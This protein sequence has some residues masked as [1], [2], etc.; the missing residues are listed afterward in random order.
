VTPEDLALYWN[1]AGR[2]HH[3]PPSNRTPEGFDPAAYLRRCFFS[4]V[5]SVLEFGCG[6]GRL[7]PPFSDVDYLGVDISAAA[8]DAASLAHPGATGRF[9]RIPYGGQI[10]RSVQAGFAYTVLLHV[11]D[12]QLALIVSTITGSVTGRF[13]VAEILGR[14]WRAPGQVDPPVFNREAQE[15]IDVFE[16]SGWQFSEL[17]ARR[18]EHYRGRGPGG[19]DE[20]VSFLVFEK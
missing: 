11:P 3:T 12:D 18:Y 8:I 4:D 2:R 17:R 10:P 16:E 7:Y 6:A 13:V 20:M 15:Y 5:S 14:H 19:R 1:D 9:W